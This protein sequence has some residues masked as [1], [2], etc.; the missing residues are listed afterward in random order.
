MNRRT[1][2]HKRI[3]WTRDS[4]PA[5]V[6]DVSLSHRRLY[7]FATGQLLNGAYVIAVFKDSRN[8]DRTLSRL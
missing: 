1:H 4:S 6:Q 8:N 3:G 5:G 2:P 7:I